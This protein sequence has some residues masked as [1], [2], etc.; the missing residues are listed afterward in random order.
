M[1]TKDMYQIEI[2]T[3]VPIWVPKGMTEEQIRAVVDLALEDV[4]YG[5][6]AEQ[7]KGIEQADSFEYKLWLDN[8][9]PDGGGTR[10]A[11]MTK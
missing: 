9:E 5:M 1:A 2:G 8:G 4:F 11:A 10:W 6:S 3:T 7:T